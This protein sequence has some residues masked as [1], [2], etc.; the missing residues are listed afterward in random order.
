MSSIQST[1][2]PHG[3]SSPGR[4]HIRQVA[5]D[6]RERL[7]HGREKLQQQHE[8]GSPGIQVSNKLTT[9]FDE[10]VVDVFEATLA[11][12]D[13]AL[14][15]RLRANV[16][17][18]P[19]G[20]FGRRDSAPYSD[21]DLMLLYHRSVK[22]DI[23]QLSGRLITDLGDAGLSLGFNARELN[24]TCNLACSDGTILTSLCESRYLAGNRELFDRFA[25]RFKRHIMRRW[26]RLYPV[27]ED[28]RRQE[29]TKFGE[30]VFL[31]EPN[32]K[33]SRG[34]MRDVQLIRW[35]G[36]LRYGESEPEALQRAGH[37]SK[38]DFMKLRDA[39]DFLLRLRND[40]HFH[41]GKANDLLDKSEQMRIAELLGYEGDEAVL[42]VE[43]FMQD[44]FRHTTEV[45]NIASYFARRHRPQ[46]ITA[47]VLNPLVAINV[48]GDF[49]LGPGGIK[50][51]RRGREKL[52]GNL[53]EVLRLMDLANMAD[54]R[55]DEATWETIRQ[56]MSESDD[57][58]LTSEAIERFLSLMSQPARLGDM[59]RRLHELHV[60]EKIEPG[61]RHA[62]NLLQ[63]NEYHKLTVDAHCIRAVEACTEFLNHP[64]RIGQVYRSIKQ[65]RTL[66]LALLI[67]DLGKGFAEDHSEVGRRLAVETSRRLNLSLRE[68]RRVEFLVHKHLM[69]SHLAFRRDISD[70]QVVI[71]FAV[72]VG[73]P[74]RLKMLYVLT[75]S[76]LQAV[77]P[78]VLNDWKLDVLTQLYHGA[79]RHLA[80]DASLDTDDNLR[81]SRERVRASLE[82]S[83]DADWFRRQIES[84]SP[85]YLFSV[86][87]RQIVED[88]RRVRN[89]TADAATAW[90]RYLPDRDVVEYT[91][92][93]YDQCAPGLFHRLTGALTSNRMQ[94][95]SAEINT[96]ADGLVI[97]RFYVE[98]AVHQGTVSSDRLQE[99]SQALI[100]AATDAED[101]APRF[102]RLWNETTQGVGG[103][104]RL[105][106]RVR[107]D[108][109]TSENFTVIDVFAHDRKGL[110]Y[111]IT[112]ALHE[113]SA[114]VAVAKIGT[115]LDQVVDVFY[116]TDLRSGG[117]IE[118]EDRV[119]EI[120]Q[121]LLEA[122][123]GTAETAVD[124]VSSTG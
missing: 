114:S 45:R 34:G 110:L 101:K 63:F 76:D 86:E 29:R 44:Y 35:L 48:E 90:G 74:D 60:L 36:F 120:R 82:K 9:L 73:S 62:R 118:D 75:A 113:C 57:I 122:I 12:M 11:E 117:K 56:S 66:H 6:A 53:A 123:D 72:E 111:A 103:Y 14:A 58:E 55:I 2:A 47:S 21:I 121:R 43:R 119:S 26:R 77:G 99:V 38:L 5:L 100:R 41:A 124:T 116:V 67:H 24:E 31:L 4:P 109:D 78:G 88:L 64:G 13:K 89:L 54:K 30:T 46:S 83:D 98:D 19:N 69:M 107:F 102:S 51:T 71:D 104:V 93:A 85:S 18:V 115:Y 80:G 1:H 28:A 17:L 49:R 52:A 112:R 22:S 15:D 105:P 39:A 25:S 16:A 79:M 50:A 84:V 87:P 32:I 68:A 70:E 97:D 33:R 8:A 27:I 7:S 3:T 20:G 23:Q 108:N 96:L 37:R 94:I 65:K 40:M 10:I 81:R 42:P 59:L 61:F 95:L 106:T 91:V 92:G